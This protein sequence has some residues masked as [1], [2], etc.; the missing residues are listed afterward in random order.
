MKPN[1]FALKKACM[2][3][4]I[5]FDGITFNKD[6]L[7]ILREVFGSGLSSF[8][9]YNNGE[10]SN[11][12]AN[13]NCLV[14]ETS[15]IEANIWFAEDKKRVDVFDLFEKF[16]CVLEDYFDGDIEKLSM[17]CNMSRNSYMNSEITRDFRGRIFEITLKPFHSNISL[18]DSRYIFDDRIKFRKYKGKG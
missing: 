16:L 7:D 13:F 10:V 4:E 3:Y 2:L 11:G 1:F 17:C 18:I 9:K 15:C 5:I 6:I 12:Y 14:F 8:Y